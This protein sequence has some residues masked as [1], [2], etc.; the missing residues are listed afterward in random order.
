MCKLCKTKSQAHSRSKKVE[1]IRC[2]ICHGTIEILL[3]KMN[4]EGQVVSTPVKSA[5]GFAKFVQENYAKV[6]KPNIGHADVMKILGEN[7]G[8]L[9][10]TQKA[11]FN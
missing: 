4:K 7:F 3:N 9:T 8:Q 11:V 1:N 10:V 6:K 2:K 5:T